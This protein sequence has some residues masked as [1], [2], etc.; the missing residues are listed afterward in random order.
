[1]TKNYVIICAHRQG[2]RNSIIL[3][4]KNSPDW[5]VGKYNLP[6]GK[7]EEGEGSGEAA[8]R[9]L[10]EE[11]GY[12][13][14]KMSL[15]GCI[16]DT[17]EDLKDFRDYE[18]STIFCFRAIISKDAGEM[19]PRPEETETVAWHRWNKVYTSRRLI[20]NLRVIV[21]LMLNGCWDWTV[22][23]NYRSSVNDYHQIK[24]DVM[25]P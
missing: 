20:P 3:V 25:S 11:T 23:D 8:H 19:A 22:T 16:Q 15:M 13:A 4:K 6:G 24:V 21:P 5:Q 10:K 14:L 12:E 2:D 7:I 17:D 18:G 1:M 9:E